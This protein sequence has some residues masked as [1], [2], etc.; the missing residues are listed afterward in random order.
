MIKKIKFVLLFLLLTSTITVNANAKKIAN[1]PEA[2]GICYIEKTN[3]LIVVNDEGWVYKLTPKGDIKR[4]FFLGKYDLEGITYDKKNDKLLV[5][6]EGK[7]S[8]LVLNRASLEIEKEIKI[9]RKFE[10]INLLKK[11]K[12]AGIEAIAI[13]KDGD[14]YLSNQ[15][16]ITY[17]KN[18]KENASVVFKIDSIKKKKAKIVKVFNHGYKD[19]AGLT[20]HDGYLYMTSDKKNLLIKYD[21]KNNKTIKK[22]NLPKSAQEGICF[23]NEGYVYIA[24][25]NGFILRYKVKKLGI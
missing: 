8:I 2:S 19:I 4:K 15:S 14:I 21:I 5:A 3:M 24:D 18:I 17:K 23:D 20:F 13:D 6:V 16:K 7:E 1:I 22:I 12:K 25:D 11:S 10:K 9:K